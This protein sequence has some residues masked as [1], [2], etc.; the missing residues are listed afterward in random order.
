V[1][2][3][4]CTLVIGSCFFC[5]LSVRD[6]L[7]T[8]ARA[9]SADRSAPP[10]FYILTGPVIVQWSKVLRAPYPL[11]VFFLGPIFLSRVP[12]RSFRSPLLTVVSTLVPSDF[13]FA[14]LLVSLFFGGPNIFHQSRHLV[15]WFFASAIVLL[16][17]SVPHAPS[18]DSLKCTREPCR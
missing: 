1:D 2:P 3:P 4:S 8:L 18:P 16:L 15:F 6:F 14:L 13:V 7:K 10:F 17:T 9:F 12:P 5:G 11:T